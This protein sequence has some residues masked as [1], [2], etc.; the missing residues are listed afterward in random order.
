M[1][2]RGDRD[3]IA[4][5]AILTERNLENIPEAQRQALIEQHPLRRLGTP[6]D[7]AAAASPAIAVVSAI[8]TVVLLR[9]AGRG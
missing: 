1:S 7:V 5:E 4:P 2:R 8:G 6:E 3:C 9:D